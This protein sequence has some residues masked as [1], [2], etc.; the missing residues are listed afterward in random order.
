MKR[1]SFFL[2]LVFALLCAS[3]SAQQDHYTA[4]TIF[5]NY[6]SSIVQV[7]A[8]QQLQNGVYTSMATGFIIS[9]GLILTTNHV[10]SR[11]PELLA[12]LPN[13][14]IK[15]SDGRIVQAS[16]I[17]SAPSEESKLHDYAILRTSENLK[18]AG[19]RI[20]R[21]QDV[22]EGDN[23]TT[24]G[25]ALNLTD[26]FLLSL[27]VAGSFPI[28]GINAITF[29]GPANRGLS[30]APLIS[31]QTGYVVG[32]VSSR[33]VGITPALVE[34]RNQIVA[35]QQSSGIRL[36]LIGVDPNAAILEL[37]NVLDAD[38]MSGMGA[39][40]VIDYASAVLPKTKR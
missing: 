15:L 31:N 25:Y 3:V 39:A 36:R 13:I 6:R 17:A 8:S 27:T 29:Q 18:V 24:I 33:L 1:I 2:L 20:G 12:Y 40:I 37:T 19:L 16:P 4:K 23:L 38:L 32:I 30:G 28:D 11:P 5:A 21:W 10:V 26:P 14:K 34:I 7:I 9:G 35:G 22:K